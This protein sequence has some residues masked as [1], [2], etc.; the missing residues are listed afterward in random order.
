MAVGHNSALAPSPRAVI[1]IERDTRPTQEMTRQQHHWRRRT[2]IAREKM[3][4]SQSSSGDLFNVSAS[5]GVDEHS[6]RREIFNSPSLAHTEHD[7]HWDTLQLHAG[8][9]L[10]SS[11]LW[12]TLG[13]NKRNFIVSWEEEREQPTAVHPRPR[14]FAK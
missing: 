5:R 9:V 12:Q 3:S 2:V 7:D 10:D 1:A 6:W 11:L 8:M 4:P 14:L 13:H